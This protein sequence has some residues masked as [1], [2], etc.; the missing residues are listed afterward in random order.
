[1]DTE[2]LKPNGIL[3]SSHVQYTCSC[4]KYPHINSSFIDFKL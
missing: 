1:M 4:N 2:V 3:M